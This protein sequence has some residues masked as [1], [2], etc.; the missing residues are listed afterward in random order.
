MSTGDCVVCVLGHV[1]K[2]D[3]GSFQ[4][5]QDESPMALC[6]HANKKKLQMGGGVVLP[7]MGKYPLKHVTN[8]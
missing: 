7:P 2:R 8:K 6:V 1:S 5:C 3:Y 4:Q